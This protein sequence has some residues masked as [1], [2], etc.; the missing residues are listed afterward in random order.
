QE[1]GDDVS[2]V[3]LEPC[4]CEHNM[5]L[6]NRG[7]NSAQIS[8]GTDGERGDR[9]SV[10]HAEEHPS[11]EKGNE[12]AVGFAQ[13]DVLAAGVRKH[14]SQFGKGN[15]AKERDDGGADP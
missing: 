8:G 10:A 7:D 9:S 13:I 3:Y 2:A 15:A 1:Y 12:I 6:R 4:D 14:R 11:V 5:R